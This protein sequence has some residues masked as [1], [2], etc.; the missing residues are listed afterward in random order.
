MQNPEVLAMSIFIWFTRKTPAFIA[1]SGFI[2][3][4]NRD[5]AVLE[6]CQGKQGPGYS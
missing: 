2:G 5:P 4:V 3:D 6:K 1:V